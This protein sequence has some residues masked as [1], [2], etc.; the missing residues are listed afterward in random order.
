MDKIKPTIVY[1]HHGGDLNID[2]RKTYEAVLTATR[3]IGHDYV[4]EIYC[5]E[6]VYLEWNFEYSNTF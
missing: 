2:H 4:E 6:T 3:P 1:T 5:F